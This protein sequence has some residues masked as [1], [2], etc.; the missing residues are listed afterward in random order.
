[1]GRGILSILIAAVLCG[2]AVADDV[3][4][5]PPALTA[6]AVHDGQII[7]GAE[8]GLLLRLDP[9]AR[10]AV[11]LLPAD[12]DAIRAVLVRADGIS[13][14]SARGLRRLG[15][16]S[17]VAWLSGPWTGQEDDATQLSACTALVDG[18]D[19]LYLH[20]FRSIY[21]LAGG[22]IQPLIRSSE[23]IS[24]VA[25]T[26]GTVW[27]GTLHGLYRWAPGLTEA[28]AVSPSQF[29]LMAP[30]CLLHHAR[31]ARED[32]FATLG[33]GLL[34]RGADGVWQTD[35]REPSLLRL[36]PLADG[37]LALAAPAR[38]RLLTADG[39]QEATVPFPP[40]AYLAT[41]GT[42][43]AA[44]V[45]GDNRCWW[46]QEDGAWEELFAGRTQV[47]YRGA[48]RQAAPAGAA[49]PRW[50]R[51]AAWTALAAAALLLLVVWRRRRAAAPVPSLPAD[52]PPVAWQETPPSLPPLLPLPAWRAQLEPLRPALDALLGEQERLVAEHAA[53]PVAEAESE[54]VQ[55]R[56]RQR[57]QEL[58]ER[59]AGQQQRMRECA[60]RLTEE[61]SGLQRERESLQADRARL[62]ADYRERRLDRGECRAWRRRLQARQAAAEHELAARR[63][64]QREFTDVLTL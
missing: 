15:S 12:G 50:H 53:L 63:L 52:E 60:Q 28:E 14:L 41:A 33:A 49:A 57:T 48:P 9:H 32:L 30:L 42:L 19:A 31:H 35:T 46:R 13:I 25:V 64:L 4:L 44:I 21:R 3:S 51:P 45:P 40:S 47:Y 23:N 37:V 7:V 5:I 39:W 55:T 58:K 61:L 29:G 6:V 20:G 43:T 17:S 54:A 2:T 36:W 16:D 34:R 22:E 10:T 24:T 62:E 56:F 59:V 18:D 11:T 1:M 26:E 27:F 8:D 38:W